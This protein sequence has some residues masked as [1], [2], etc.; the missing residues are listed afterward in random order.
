MELKAI[1]DNRL[2]GNT[3]TGFLKTVAIFFMI[4]DHTAVVFFPRVLELRLLGRIA[5][6]LFAWCG[7]V[8][9]VYTRNH[10]R[11]ML[12][13]FVFM[14][15]SQPFYALALSH[16]W[17]E[18]NIFATLLT[19]QLALFGIRKKW[20]GSQYWAPVL[21]ILLGCLF[22][23]DYG[24]KGVLVIILLYMAKETRSGLAAA[25]IAYCLFWGENTSLMNTICGVSLLP[26]KTMLPY[27][28]SL[29]TTALRLENFAVLSLPFMLLP[30][31]WKS[32]LPRWISYS[33]YPAHLGLLYALK[34]ILK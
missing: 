23:M 21:C 26:L 34:L 27:G 3:N 10:I 25:M 17:Y 22:K 7:V 9:S 12:R 11:Y 16:N 5:F 8:G 15:V 13:L 4:I 31:G 1:K 28:S 29:Y 33:A 18:M 24:W 20:H 32:K 30:I 6:P 19:G 14:A 2:A